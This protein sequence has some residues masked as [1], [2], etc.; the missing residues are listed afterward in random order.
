[1]CF[2]VILSFLCKLYELDCLV[3][4]DDVIVNLHKVGASLPR[5]VEWVE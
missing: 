3:Y 4:V 1:M 5:N 2:L